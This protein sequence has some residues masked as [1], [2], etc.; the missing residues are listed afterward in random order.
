M[1]SGQPGS[2]GTGIV[3]I[4]EW[5]GGIPPRSPPPVRHM[6][7]IAALPEHLGGGWPVSGRS[8]PRA[9]SQGVRHKSAFRMES[10]GREVPEGRFGCHVP[11]AHLT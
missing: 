3:S 5:G 2:T 7:Q 1:G 11:A 4:A 10:G 9:P 6:M 8:W